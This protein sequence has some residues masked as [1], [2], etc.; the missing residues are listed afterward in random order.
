MVRTANPIQPGTQALFLLRARPAALETFEKFGI[1]PWS[2]QSASLELLCRNHGVAWENMEA[3]LM[4]LP[5]PPPDANWRLAPLPLFLDHLVCEHG[6]ILGV[7]LPALK[8]ALAR[9]N[10]EG[11]GGPRLAYLTETVPGIAE[12]L[13][14]HM[15]EEEDFLFPRLLQ[16][17]HSARHRGRHPDFAEGSVNVFIAI[18]LLGNENRQME[19]LS[20][21][22]AGWSAASGTGLPV[23]GAEADLRS[24]L[25]V[26][27]DRIMRHSAMEAD[28]LFPRA[29]ALEKSLYDAAISGRA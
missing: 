24:A 20:R 25:D 13:A 14:A 2:E 28:I 17:D 21:F 29:K 3:G 8:R 6:Q 16:Y 26:F 11:R 9:A 10:E 5:D 27:Q 22:L 4:T 7:L 23:S 15:R 12:Q 18:H 19:A 1:D